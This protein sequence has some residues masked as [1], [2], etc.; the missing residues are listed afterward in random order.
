MSRKSREEVYEKEKQKKESDVYRGL[1]K[2][3]VDKAIMEDQVKDIIKVTDLWSA[4]YDKKDIA[5]MCAVREKDVKEILRNRG[6]DF[7]KSM[8]LRIVNR[9][10]DFIDR[11]MDIGIDDDKIKGANLVHLTQSVEKLARS[12]QIIDRNKEKQVS[13]MPNGMNDTDLLQ[14]GKDAAVQLKDI[15]FSKKVGDTQ[16]RIRMTANKGQTRRVRTEAEVET[17]KNKV[18]QQEKVNEDAAEAIA[19][20][21][22]PNG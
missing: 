22:N 13:N 15:E 8:K 19:K 4:G 7:N 21:M 3:N 5:R 12:M 14:L 6:G 17:V 9:I 10:Y 20:G 2:E 11:F 18:I 1:V 16:M